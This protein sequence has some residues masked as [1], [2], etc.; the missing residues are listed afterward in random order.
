MES[1]GYTWACKV[2]WFG[3][4]VKVRISENKVGK[5]SWALIVEGHPECQ[6]LNIETPNYSL[7]TE[8]LLKVLNPGN[9]RMQLYLGSMQVSV[10][11][12][13]NYVLA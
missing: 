7:H 8:N 11:I 10:V 5:I 3:Q 13:I 4:R 1:S 9:D 6:A 12:T 2:D